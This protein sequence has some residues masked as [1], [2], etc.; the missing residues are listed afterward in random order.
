M[1]LQKKHIGYSVRSLIAILCVVVLAGAAAVWAAPAETKQSASQ[2][3]GKERQER[4]K[5]LTDHMANRLE[6]KASQQAAWQA[7]TKSLQAAVESAVKK[8]ETKSDAASIARM[9]ADMAMERAQRLAQIAD[10][11]A[12]L[13]EVLTPD[14]RATLDQMAAK[15]AG[16]RGGHHGFRNG[17][18]GGWE[19]Q[20]HEHEHDDGGHAHEQR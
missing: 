18:Y 4:F 14:Q 19:G 15:F 9:R 13:Q 1:T 6:I 16:R 11:T 8:P 17:E 2:D 7:F 12:G 20:E 10:A 3:W 5:Q